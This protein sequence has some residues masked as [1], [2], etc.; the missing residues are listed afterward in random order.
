MQDDGERKPCPKTKIDAHKR[1]NNPSLVGQIGGV[2][3]YSFYFG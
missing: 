3:Q 1:D 2:L